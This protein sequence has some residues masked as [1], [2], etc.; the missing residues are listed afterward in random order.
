[1][2]A[3]N[4]ASMIDSMA[5]RSGRDAS[6]PW[7]SPRATATWRSKCD[8]KRGATALAGG[9]WEDLR[10]TIKRPSL[11]PLPLRGRGERLAFAVAEGGLPR[12]ERGKHR[13]VRGVRLQRRDGDEALAHGVNVRHL[14]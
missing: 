11:Y 8:S 10:T 12:A 9:Y 1:M 14:V 3:Q 4:A 2:L 13:V 5:S 6:E 7:P